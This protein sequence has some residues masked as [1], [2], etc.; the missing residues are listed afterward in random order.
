MSLKYLWLSVLVVILDQATKWIA[1][2]QLEFHQLT[3]VMPYFDWYLAYNKGAAFSFL[4]DQGGWQ[5]WF[6]TALISI[7]SIVL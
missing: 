4:A 3:P 5:R 2:T 1:N 6:F 7:I